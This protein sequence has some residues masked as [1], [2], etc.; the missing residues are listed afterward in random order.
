MAELRDLTFAKCGNC[1][2][3]DASKMLVDG[4]GKYVGSYCAPCGKILTKELQSI[5]DAGK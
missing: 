3:K 5:E 2:V 1:K 4:K